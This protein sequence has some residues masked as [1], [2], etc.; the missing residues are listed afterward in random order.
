[1]A[2]LFAYLGTSGDA[3]VAARPQAAT[4]AQ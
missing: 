3:A 4:T 2:D 1:V